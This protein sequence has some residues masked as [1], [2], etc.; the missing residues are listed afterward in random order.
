MARFVTPINE[1]ELANARNEINEKISPVIDTLCSRIRVVYELGR[2]VKDTDL[3]LGIMNECLIILVY[4]KRMNDKL[5]EYHREF[6]IK[7]DERL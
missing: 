1:T 5:V 6:H 2:Q 7:E 3:K 4:A